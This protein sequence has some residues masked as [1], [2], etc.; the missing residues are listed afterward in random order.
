VLRWVGWLVT[1]TLVAAAAY[2]LQLALLHEISPN[3]ES[4]ILLITLVAML[5]G[6]VLVFRYVG[7]AWLFAPAAALFVTARFYTGDPYYEPFFRSYSDG[8]LF[9]PVWVLGLLGLAVLAGIAA[10]LWRRTKPVESAILLLLLA[11]TAL[12]M[13]AGH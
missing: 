8:G 5:T 12:F 6:T 10:Q 4:W 1:G 11:F 9:S 3:G 2:E 7:T 13:S